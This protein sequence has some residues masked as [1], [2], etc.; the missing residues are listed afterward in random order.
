MIALADITDGVFSYLERL[1]V[2]KVERPHGLPKAKRQVRMDRERSTA[3]LD[4]LL[5]S[6]GLAVELDGRV[7]HPVEARWQDIHRDNF[8]AATGI[9][10]LR[11]SWADIT[12]RPC[13]V[14][15]QI[16]VLLRQRGWTGTFRRCG[17]MCQ[18]GSS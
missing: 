6:Y 9:I 4:N 2:R 18:A 10:T 3:Y 5:D 1:Y 17:P 16:A 7:A 8:F 14:A 13:L 15:A 11:Y 12:N